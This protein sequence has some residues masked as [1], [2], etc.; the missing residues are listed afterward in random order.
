MEDGGL[1]ARRLCGRARIVH[2]PRG[3]RLRASRKPAAV[4]CARFDRKERRAALHSAIW[5][6]V[7]SRLAAVYPFELNRRHWRSTARGAKMNEAVD[8]IRGRNGP[9]VLVLKSQ[10]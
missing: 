3:H 10:L 9:V 7:E 6:W 2:Y 4:G 1:P 5:P 8:R